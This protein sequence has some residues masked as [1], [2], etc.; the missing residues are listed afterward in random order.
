VARQT[1]DP[2]NP[3]QFSVTRKWI[4][5]LVVCLQVRHYGSDMFFFN[6]KEA[7]PYWWQFL[8]SLFASVMSAIYTPIVNETAREF[9]VSLTVAAVPLATYLVGFAVGP[10]PLTPLAEVCILQA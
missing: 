8:Q 10:V 3:F 4:I 6:K 1:R 2:E 5:C 9:G 7:P